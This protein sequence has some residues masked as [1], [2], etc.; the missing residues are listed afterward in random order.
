MRSSRMD[1]CSNNIIQINFMARKR[2]NAFKVG[3]RVRLR[4]VALWQP[5]AVDG[6]YRKWS[7]D[8]SYVKDPDRVYQIVKERPTL[9][10]RNKEGVYHIAGYSEDG[11][12]LS[13]ANWPATWH[14]TAW[15][16]VL[17]SADIAQVPMNQYD[18]EVADGVTISFE[19]R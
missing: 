8:S 4:P 16:G 17:E 10:T 18:V 7:L 3:D 12:T 19:A 13:N 11:T 6:Y 5:L 2:R 15:D 14:D 9:K 1:I